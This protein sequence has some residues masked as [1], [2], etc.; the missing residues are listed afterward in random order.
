MPVGLERVHYLLA[1]K[2]VEQFGSLM[3]SFLNCLLHPLQLVSHKA[4]WECLLTK[5]CSHIRNGII[6]STKIGDVLI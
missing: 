3:L 1:G 5:V 2:E 6:A 4:V